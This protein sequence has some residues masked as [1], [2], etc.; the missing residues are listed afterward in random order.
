MIPNAAS[1]CK[2]RE[3]QAPVLTRWLY[4]GQVYAR[5]RQRYIVQGETDTSDW[6]DT[7]AAARSPRV[8]CRGSKAE[9]LTG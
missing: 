8:S 2:P 9:G 5:I 6:C 7:M 4:V 1:A 3:G